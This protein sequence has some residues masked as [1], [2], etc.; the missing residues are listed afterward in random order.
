MENRPGDPEDAE[1]PGV[2]RNWIPHRSQNMVMA[3]IEN[4]T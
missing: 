4:V 2:P 1:R 3:S